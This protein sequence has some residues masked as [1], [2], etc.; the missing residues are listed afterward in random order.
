MLAMCCVLSLIMPGDLKR[1]VCVQL[2][3]RNTHTFSCALWRRANPTNEGVARSC[4]PWRNYL[5]GPNEI[6]C[7]PR[8]GANRKHKRD[9]RIS[10]L[11]IV[12]HPIWIIFFNLFDLVLSW[13][14]F[15]NKSWAANLDQTKHIKIPKPRV[16]L[17]CALQ[18]LRTSEAQF[19]SNVRRTLRQ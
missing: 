19:R 18:G 11:G 16:G 12:R 4:S 7:T 15:E 10:S 3:W 17:V 5:P 6:V 13:S 9:D 1:N 8:L 14:L 2:G